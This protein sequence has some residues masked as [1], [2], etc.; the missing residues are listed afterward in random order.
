MDAKTADMFN[1]TISAL[2][3]LAVALDDR[4]VLQKQRY[5]DVLRNWWD[6][7]TE[8]DAGGGPGFVFERLIDLLSTPLGQPKTG[9]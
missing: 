5:V 9:Q 8:D 3:A 7:M 4:N 2:A 6:Q 1:G